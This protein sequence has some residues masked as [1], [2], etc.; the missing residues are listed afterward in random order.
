MDKES[1]DPVEE[2]LQ[3]WFG[4]L[5][6]DGRADAQHTASWFKKDPDFDAEIVRRFTGLYEAFREEK[7]PAWANG[8][9]GLLAAILVLDQFSRNMFRDNAKMY[10]F[11][12]RALRLSFEY[13]ALG[14]DEDAP[15]AHR[16]FSYM[17]LMHSERLVDQ[18]RC[19]TLFSRFAEELSGEL[20]QAIRANLK[21]AIAHRD[22]V[23]RFGRFPHRNAILGRE[24]TK[25]ELAFLSEP[26]SSF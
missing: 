18:E 2:V 19:V 6:D 10:A 22:I 20:E 7:L 23:A 5:D 16:T 12:E 21:F 15:T 26:G 4:T 8:P 24:S 11:D 17:P 14:F 9:R 25:E 13:I 1:K 3:F